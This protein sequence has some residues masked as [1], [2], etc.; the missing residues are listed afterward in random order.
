MNRT[1]NKNVFPAE[2]KQ[3]ML[4]LNVNVVTERLSGLFDFKVIKG[5]ETTVQLKHAY[6]G[7]SL[8]SPSVANGR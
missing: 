1:T 7:T 4:I 8:I 6:I 5:H 2:I 3:L